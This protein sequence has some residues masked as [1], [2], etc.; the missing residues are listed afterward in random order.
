MPSQKR[1]R[2]ILAPDIPL[3]KLVRAYN[4]IRAYQAMCD[5]P[6]DWQRLAR[7][8]QRVPPCNWRIW[9]VMA[10]RGFGKT[11]M[12]AETV[13]QWVCQEGYRRIALIGATR[14]E[15][16][17]VMVEGVSGILAISPPRERPVF[18]KSKDQLV[19]P[20]GAVAQ[21]FSAARAEKLRGPQF[22]AA[23]IDEFAKFPKADALWD[24]AMM[25]IRL[26]QKPRIVITTT[27]R[28]LPLLRALM[29][30]PDVHLTRGSTFDNQENL[31]PAFLDNLMQHYA[32]T[33]LGAQE[34][35]AHVL[36]EAE[37]ALWSRSLIRY[38]QPPPDPGVWQRIV[39]GVD[40]AVSNTE[41]SDETGIIVVGLT[42]EGVAYV[43]ADHSMRASPNTWAQSVVSCYRRW[44]ADLVVAE[45]NKGGDLVESVLRVVDATLSYRGVTATKG[46]VTRAEP[47]AA[48]YDQGRVVHAQPFEVLE[49]QMTRFVPGQTMTASPDRVDALVWALT[50]LLLKPRPKIAPPRV[51]LA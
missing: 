24:Q 31:A 1:P 5:A 46:K 29:A 41:T 27:P 44:Q 9:L 51:W 47:V 36:D 19:W 49:E 15:V 12:G 11:R 4:I 39:I 35:Y 8:N 48:L 28:P 42:K 17:A 25:S 22:E 45:K 26:G 50:E 7:P 6:Y 23:W 21:I 32:H 43:L 40:P 33:R 14:D 30:R 13:R 3:P 16:R 38:M 18:Y 10:G 2:Y 20:N 37:G 34:I